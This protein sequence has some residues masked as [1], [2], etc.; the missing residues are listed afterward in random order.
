MTCSKGVVLE[1]E[2]RRAEELRAIRDVL[3]IIVT[4]CADMRA[5]SLS[6]AESQV[7]ASFLT[8][9]DEAATNEAEIEAMKVCAYATDDHG[10]MIAEKLCNDSNKVRCTY[11]T[12][13]YPDRCARSRLL[14]ELLCGHHLDSLHSTSR[15]VKNALK[16]PCPLEKAEITRDALAAEVTVLRATFSTVVRGCGCR[17]GPGNVPPELVER[18]DRCRTMKTVLSNLSPMTEHLLAVTKAAERWDLAK[19]TFR[20]LTIKDLN[21]GHVAEIRQA[22]AELQEAVAAW[23]KGCE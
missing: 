17:K 13:V 6:Q 14:K 8:A 15:D 23:K 22:E 16:T 11:F 7:I 9:I 1:A 12:P 18:C 19:G 2:W 4:K 3:R 20:G 10:C 5:M 21:P